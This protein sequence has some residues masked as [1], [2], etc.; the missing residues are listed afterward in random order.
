MALIKCNECG[1]EISD[2][3]KACPH[4]GY[5]NNLITCPECKKRIESNMN[6]CSNCGYEI[7]KDNKQV[8]N[9]FNVGVMIWLVICIIACF[10]MAFL[11]G[12]GEILGIIVD[13]SIGYLAILLGISYVV[14]LVNQN[15]MSL[16]ILL[17]INA[18]I[19]VFSLFPMITVI[20]LLNIFCAIVNATITSLVVRKSLCSNKLN[21]FGIV[22]YIATIIILIVVFI[23]NFSNNTNNSNNNNL[24]SE[25]QQIFDTLI[26]FIDRN[27]FYN[28]SAL[29]VLKIRIEDDGNDYP[30]LWVRF[31]GTN[32]IGGT[33]S[34][35]YKI[36]YNDRGMG[37]E[38]NN[39]TC[40]LV[41][42]YLD[43]NL[44][45]ESIKKINSELENYW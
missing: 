11:N 21:L 18:I 35:C 38:V 44:S 10:G 7:K 2:T 14:L 17:G 20:S 12:F 15:K 42:Q 16:Y 22:S 24:S 31:S 9:K 4:C 39:D 23:F 36:F 19:L 29:R 34:K 5:E 30:M 41:F 37:D 8:K 3:A 1:K 43:G 40:D 45:Q 32:K 6:T 33:I 26:S 27:N 13:K 25:E 28:P